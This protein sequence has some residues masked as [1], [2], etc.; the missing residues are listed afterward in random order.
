MSMVKIDWNP[1]AAAMRGFGR[2]VFIGFTTIGVALWLFGGSL[3]ETRES[4]SMVWGPLPGFVG[5]SAAVWALAVLAPVAARPIYRIWM[6]I[7]FVMGT[8]ISTTLL[9]AIYWILFGFIALC[10]RLRRRDR[11]KIGAAAGQEPGWTVR[12]GST[13]RERYERQF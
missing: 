13:P 12:S 10:F 5:I 1:N 6:S 9:A 4:G 8:I 3:A 7:A 2:T 11:L